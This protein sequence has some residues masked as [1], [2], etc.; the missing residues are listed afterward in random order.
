MSASEGAPTGDPEL[1]E[2][3]PP[4]VRTMAIVRW[5]LVGIMA[6]A[7]VGSLLYATG[8]LEKLAGAGHKSGGGT[9]YYCPM[10]PSVVQDHPGECPICSMTLVP[11]SESG[12]SA[13]SKPAAP[14]S[15]GMGAAGSKPAASDKYYCPMHPNRTSNDPNARCPDCGMK[16]VPKLSAKSADSGMPA[17]TMSAS[18][19]PG[20]PGLAPVDLS[21]ERIQ[22]TGMRT[23]EAK[24]EPLRSELR[25]VGVV[26]ENERG[27]AQI[28]TR[29]AGWVQKLMVAETG[30][31]VSR[32]Q[33]LATI[34]SPDVLRAE[35]EYITARRW[36]APGGPA[37]GGE[38][39]I[40]SANLAEDARRRLELLGLAEPEL[41]E[42]GKTGQ[43]LRDVAIRSPVNGTVIRRDA[44]EGSY[45][46]PGAS[47]FAVADLSTV[48]VIAD[49][50]EHELRRVR[51][52]QAARLN[53]T[54]YP[55]ETFTG[56]VQ[57]LYPTIDP[58]TRTMRV[59][60]EFRNPKQTLKPGMYATVRLDLPPTEGLVVPAE[61]VVDT[62]EVQYV[63]IAKPG[64]HF[65]P[66]RVKVGGRT[67][68]DAEILDGLAEGETV[69]TTSNF[70]IDSESRLRAAIEGQMSSGATPSSGGGPGEGPSCNEIDKQK[71]PDKFQSCRACEIQHRGMGTMEEDCKK[72]IPQPWR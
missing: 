27:L 67:D 70:L 29:F 69:V 5:V 4:G 8:G 6:L 16:M 55:G 21:P 49:V 39:G 46:Q 3:V 18:Q 31:K 43:A 22:L 42:L 30:R 35:Q 37:V 44:V 53:V 34:Y 40:S 11:K 17:M 2:H 25:T 14:T 72:A 13:P 57:F 12:G 59:R 63:F 52:G 60:L 28:N 7:A 47:L 36:S 68:G 10:H 9:L 64:G 23:G 32:G 45:V 41:A 19:S 65:E 62:G 24:R 15:D 66:R 48:W 20:V 61:A 38:H 71:Y 33:V 51:V 1:A 26:S 56:K 50:Y 58:E 54:A